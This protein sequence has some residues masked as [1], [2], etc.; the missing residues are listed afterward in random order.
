MSVAPGGR[1]VIVGTGIAGATAA[2][3]LRKEG[4]AGSIVLVGADP[5]H[6]YRRP[7]VSK[8]LLAGTAAPAKAALKPVS[9]WADST[10]DLRLGVTVRAVDTAAARVVFD[11]GVLAYDALIL[12]TGGRARSLDPMPA[13]AH[14]LRHLHDPAPLR[15]VFDRLSATAA[16]PAVLVIGGGL[17]GMEAAAAARG[18]GAEVTV[19]EMGD[20]VLERVLPEPIS[21]SYE[22][23]HRARGVSVCTGVR[24]AELRSEEGERT[25]AI[26]EDGREWVADAVIVA[27]GMTPDTEV[28]DR[29]GITVADGIVVDEFGA[30]SAA[31]VYAAGDVARLPNLILGGDERVEHW[32]HAQAHGAAAARSVLGVGAPYTEVPWCWTNQFGRTLQLAGWPGRGDNL[33]VHGDLDG[34]SFLV[35]S[36]DG[37][38]L[39]GAAGAGCPRAVR[40][41]QT[42]IGKGAYPPRHLLTSGDLDLVEMASAPDRFAFS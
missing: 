24:L 3:T 30:T 10:I 20:R 2:E 5:A 7:M 21:A 8:E 4:F 41:A 32:N 26:A 27:I 25:R 35:L 29:A 19:L 14:T 6:P 37:D 31:G 36:L 28:A 42:L 13:G 9:F 39:V 33:I 11:D 18:A 40:A 1:V 16:T 12:A 22:R 38:R 15:A 23:L 17:V 34:E